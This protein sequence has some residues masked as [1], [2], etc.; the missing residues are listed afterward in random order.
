MSGKIIS[1]YMRARSESG[2][3]SCP[4]G[5]IESL[6]NGEVI[7]VNN[8]M[9]RDYENPDNDKEQ[10][11]GEESEGYSVDL[12]MPPVLE[13]ALRHKVLPGWNIHVT[14]LPSKEVECD[15]HTED[16]WG[17]KAQEVLNEF[18]KECRHRNYFV[19]PF[20]VICAL[21]TEDG[22]HILPSS[23]VLMIPNGKAPSTVGNSDFSENKM[24]MRVVAAPCSLC[25]RIREL[26]NIKEWNGRI[27]SLDIFVTASIPLYER[28]SE[29]KGCHREGSSQYTHSYGED[30]VSCERRLTSEIFP[31]VW[32][33]EEKSD[34]VKSA[35]I[36]CADTF[37]MVKSIPLN[38]L[39]ISNDF[40]EV[41][42][43]GAGLDGFESLPLIRPNYVMHKG[44]MGMHKR[45]ISGRV[46]LSDLRFKLP[47]NTPFAA[48]VN[49]VSGVGAEGDGRVATEV[50][51]RKG[52][53][54]LHSSRMENGVFK[55]ELTEDTLPRWLFYP[56]PDARK[57]TLITKDGSISF[58][59]TKHPTLHGSYY[60][61][62]GLDLSRPEGDEVTISATHL[63]ENDAEYERRE[64]YEMPDGIW[65]SEKIEDGTGES[66]V[67]HDNLLM[68]LDVERVVACARA[69][70][71]SGLVATTS[72]TVYA[73]TTDG[74][75]LLKEMEDGTF[76]DAG[77]MADYVLR[78][79][80]SF[81]INGRMCEFLT[82]TGKHMYID[83]TVVK[84]YTSVS[85]MSVL[86]GDLAKRVRI[87][88]SG[89]GK[90]VVV[91]TRAMKLGN[92][93]EKK[94]VRRVEIRGNIERNKC[95][96]EIYGSCDLRKW[97]LLAKGGAAVGG[98]WGPGV[99]YVKVRIESEL[100]EGEEIEGM[101]VRIEGSE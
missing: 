29:M 21:R 10:I 37:R 84:E 96:L 13:F 16:G 86:S 60:W 41:V 61:C 27:Q 64:S 25:V 59:L 3:Y 80:G 23:P 42:M 28:G 45:I 31:Q 95:R 81:R 54:T 101:G 22:H 14:M 77:L 90:N 36:M 67:F 71:A 43:D 79:G 98:I 15:V 44:V 70:R 4:D 62:G 78:D 38:S 47:L 50:E 12:P 85:G 69:F 1:V 87:V 55:T 26:Y 75:F 46:T 72:P 17:I 7:G 2:E 58:P 65:R 20:M 57:L 91:M 66:I 56:D 68:R 92:P 49:C 93:E 32:T 35:S 76:R 24:D 34:G 94:R 53:N 11:G 89:S 100:S 97:T 5:E 73:F 18:M 99:R 88:S 74:I 19:E 63:G 33:P 52:G 8:V 83:G 51:F 40:T 82:T 9:S 30:G 48:M 6:E 39:S